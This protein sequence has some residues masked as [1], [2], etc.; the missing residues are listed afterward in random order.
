MHFLASFIAA[1]KQ[2][3]LTSLLTR[4]SFLLGSV[5][6]KSNAAGWFCSHFV[7]LS[8]RLNALH[9]ALDNALVT[10]TP[11]NIFSLFFK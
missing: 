11:A 2:P 6:W 7:H 1:A 3:L 4:F 8:V 5:W 9:L 10:F